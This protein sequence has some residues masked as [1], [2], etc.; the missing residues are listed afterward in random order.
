MVTALPIAIPLRPP[1]SGCKAPAPIGTVAVTVVRAV[2][3]GGSGSR[4][5]PETPGESSAAKGGVGAGST[6]AAPTATGATIASARTAS[7]AAASAFLVVGF[8]SCRSSSPSLGEHEATGANRSR[9]TARELPWPPPPQPQPATRPPRQDEGAH[10]APEEPAL[11]A[12][13]R[14]GRFSFVTSAVA[15]ATSAAAA[16]LAA[17]GGGGG[18][19]SP[20]REGIKLLSIP[21]WWPCSAHRKSQL[22]V[23]TR[24]PHWR[25]LSYLSPFACPAGW[26]DG[27]TI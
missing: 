16:A 24:T 27:D 23:T 1:L 20:R 12:R 17:G 5:S 10:P 21:A 8:S 4:A 19:D 9:P 2:F 15:G 6:A 26:F 3:A 14:G 18:D 22:A 13:R 25:A 7:I 11:V